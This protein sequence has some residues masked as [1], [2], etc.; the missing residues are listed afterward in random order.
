M[1]ISNMKRSLCWSVAIGAALC[2]PV[3]AQA[4]WPSKTVK[5]VVPSN[6]GGSPDRVTRLVAERLARKWKQP[7]IVENKA[8]AT[9][10]IGTD[11]VAKSAPD[12]YTLLSTFTSFVQVPALFKKVP[13]DTE[14][15]FTPVTQ[16]VAVDVLFLVKADS[17]YKTLPDFAA[18]AKTAKPPLSYGS[19][20]N[21]SSFHIYGEK[22]AKGLGVDLTHVPYKG[23]L[24]STSDLLG[25]QIDSAFASV[26]TALPFL[27]D[28]R[29]RALGVASGKRSKA[30]PDISTLAEQGVGLPD[31][32]G[33][34]GILAPAGT[35]EPVIQKVAADVHEILAQPDMVKILRDQGLEPV[36]STPQAFGARVRSDLTQWKR[37][38]PEVGITP[39]D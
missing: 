38:L 30:V 16:T 34:F 9:S 29:L 23:E 36:A 6:A 13:Y 1:S 33:W 7:T 25:G 12:G 37:L 39:S 10:I 20:G 35:P 3:A 11:F 28:G 5:F 8:G 14:R 17:P 27:K 32:M 24:P 18:A 21:G 15:D 22:L 2:G 19:F 4:T 31:L 26:G